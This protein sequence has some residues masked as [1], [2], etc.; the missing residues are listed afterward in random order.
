MR[1]ETSGSV[2]LLAEWRNWQAEVGVVAVLG[3]GAL[4]ERMVGLPLVDARRGSM[5]LD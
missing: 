1:T 2:T 4:K 3:S 5:Y